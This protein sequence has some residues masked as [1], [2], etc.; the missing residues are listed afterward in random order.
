[1]TNP[2]IKFFDNIAAKWDDWI[3]PEEVRKKLCSGLEEF[4]VAPH[5]KIVDI[6]C[7]TGNLTHC[8]LSILGPEGRVFSVDFSPGMLEEAKRKI[9]DT[10]VCWINGDAVELPVEDEIADRAIFY[11]VWPHFDQPEAVLYE[12][13]RYLKPGGF[14]HVWH[15]D[16][17]ETINKIHADAG[18]CVNKDILPPAENVA[19]MMKKTGLEI[20]DLVDD[21]TRYLVTARK[22][23]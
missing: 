20:T 9:S 15:T 8:I 21:E 7:G 4:G 16:S 13:L 19:A 14:L 12:S 2:K 18:P 5:E 23:R 11:S 10:R 6:G 17:K 1:M 3:D 22:T